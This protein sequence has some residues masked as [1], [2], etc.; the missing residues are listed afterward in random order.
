MSRPFRASAR[1]NRCKPSRIRASPSSKTR[2][3]PEHD[4]AQRPFAAIAVGRAVNDDDASFAQEKSA[5]LIGWNSEST[6][7]DHDEQAALGD[8]RNNARQTVQL[9]EDPIA[10]PLKFRRHRFD[11]I[12]LRA[13]STSGGM[14]HK[15]GRPA[16]ELLEHEEHCLDNLR[17]RGTVADTPA[18]HRV[19]FRETAD[20]HRS[21][22]CIG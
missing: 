14:L 13:Q 9:R 17:G 19:G 4:I 6:H 11:A 21:L 1:P 12:L 10:P 20:Q 8:Q 2:A 15:G 16:A 3:P 18:R 22:P 7:I 5:N